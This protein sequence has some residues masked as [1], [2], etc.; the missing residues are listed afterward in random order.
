MAFTVAEGAFIVRSGGAIIRGK[1]TKE[2]EHHVWIKTK[3]GEQKIPRTSIVEIKTDEEV[4]LEFKSRFEKA[5]KSSGLTEFEQL[6]AWCKSYKLKE[7]GNRCAKELIKRSPLHVKARKWLRHKR[8]DGKWVGPEDEKKE[9]EDETIDDS[10]EEEEEKTEKTE[11]EKEPET[12]E[13]VIKKAEQLVEN[14]KTRRAI[15]IV[16]RF[17]KVGEMSDDERAALEQLVIDLACEFDMEEAKKLFK[18][19]STAIRAYTLLEKV[20]TKH[21][22]VSP[23]MAKK[24]RDLYVMVRNRFL[25]SIDDFENPELRKK[26]TMHQTSISFTKDPAKIKQGF[27]A[28]SFYVRENVISDV[29]TINIPTNWKKYK[30]LSFFLY[31]KGDAPGRRELTIDAATDANNW[32]LRTNNIDWQGWR[33]VKLKIWQSG[34]KFFTHNDPVWERIT[35]LRFY[36]EEGPGGTIILDDIKLER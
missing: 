23:E 13:T 5:G 19:A 22:D 35:F 30:Y 4:F 16:E 8:V 20:Y 33:L 25:F 21:A 36:I 31:W 6:L 28:A 18:Q 7:E 3:Y 12:A 14:G 26:W 2:D 32:W 11:D 34:N 9:S 15:G 10:E 17:I 24:F 29:I 27:T 1:I